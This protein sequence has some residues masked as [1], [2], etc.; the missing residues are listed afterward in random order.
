MWPLF[1]SSTVSP[2]RYG[3]STR[4]VSLGRITTLVAMRRRRFWGWGYEDEHP[5]PMQLEAIAGVLRPLLG[6]ERVARVAPPALEELELRASR[7][8]PPESLAPI[9]TIDRFE[10]ALHSYGRSYR[11]I[12]R[13][14]RRDFKNP[15][16]LVGVP[17][18]E[19]D[20]VR[21][22]DFCESERIAVIPYGGGSSVC[23][24]VEPVVSDRFSGTLSLDLRRLDRVVEVD[25]VSRAARIQ[26]GVL[27]PSLEAQLRPLGLTLR[28]YPQSFEFSSLGGWIATRSG[29]HFATL[30]TH[31]DELVESLRVV[32]P[33]G[34]IATRR[35]PGSGAGPA[36]ERLFI[37]SEGILGVIVE[38]W[39][40]L[41]ERPRF[42]ASA[43]ARFPDFLAGARAVRALVQSGLNPQNCRLLDPL[44]AL[45]NGVGPGDCAVLLVGFESADH[46]LDAWLARAS[47][48]CRAAGGEVSMSRAKDAGSEQRTDESSAWRLAFLRA[49]YLRDE[50]I[51][52]GVLV[53]TCETAVTWDRFE[54]LHEAVMSAAREAA[55]RGGKALVTCRITHA[56]PDGAAPYFTVLAAA[57]RGGELEQWDEIK[58]AVTEAV[59]REGGTTTHHHAVGRDFRPFYER[60]RAEGF[61]LALAA[62]KRA[63]DP[64]GMLNPG[65]L[66]EPEPRS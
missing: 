8:R 5:D 31:I 20:V 11:D 66:L 15:P 40:R 48:L 2:V 37:G 38:A 59:L 50:L 29:G 46:P 4:F 17:E 64:A 36:P 24:G 57:R 61:A 45:L 7:V 62:A 16:D 56:Y 55:G 1:P 22:L 19:T 44:E 3:A 21:I 35:L 39:M 41:F 30:Y 47:E 65:V 52:L 28:H 42:R 13:A 58:A 10:R 33:T 51:A 34:V 43:S 6:V 14:L 49:P 9:V 60:E 63:L 27:G 23:G 54:A 18:N 26:A 12:V 25:R 32:T 53:E